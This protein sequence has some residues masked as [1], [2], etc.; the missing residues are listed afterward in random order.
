MK[1]IQNLKITVMML[2][3][4]WIVQRV[5]SPDAFAEALK[6]EYL[7]VGYI[8]SQF[9][10]VNQGDAEAAIK[11][12]ARTIGVIVGYDVKLTVRDF[13]TAHHFAQVLSTQPVNLIILDSWNYLEIHHEKAM[14]PMFV[15]TDQ[16]RVFTR[17]VLL[18]RDGSRIQDVSDLHGKSLNLI[19]GQ[20]SKIARHWL[21]SV[22][23][24]RQAIEPEAFFGAIEYL[25]N[26]LAT[27]LPVFFGKKDAALVNAAQ[28]ELMTELNPQLKVLQPLA[29]S[30]PMLGA[31]ICISRQGWSSA[32]FKSDLIDVLT[33]LHTIPAG[34]QILTLFK[35][36]RLV[37][38][39]P[40]YLDAV[41][42][43]S[44]SLN[45]RP[46][47]TTADLSGERRSL[48]KSKGDR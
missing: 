26:P 2:A 1:Q 7:S 41:R 37:P 5:F 15:T 33:D 3:L 20:S 38:Y 10:G 32:R 30:E 18:V 16:G 13:E 34:K 46:G 17:Y 19:S 31:V 36:G 25:P 42:E 6:K 23:N 40:S 45:P 11:T 21:D 48:S 24:T 8:Q 44:E 14:E 39:R 43:L 9:H 29:A 22:I 27:V 35:T 12:L 47:L 28:F 4:A